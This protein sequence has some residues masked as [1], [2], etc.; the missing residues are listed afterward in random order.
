MTQLKDALFSGV[1]YDAQEGLSYTHVDCTTKNTDPWTR[2][3]SPRLFKLK[4]KFMTLKAEYDRMTELGSRD[5]RPSIHFIRSCRSRVVILPDSTM[6]TALLCVVLAALVAV[7]LSQTQCSDS[8]PCPAGLCCSKWGWCGIG[9]AWCGTN[10][11]TT[12]TPTTAA[13]ITA[14]FTTA[15]PTTATPTTAAPITATF[16]T[17]TPTFTRP[18]VNNT[19]KQ[20]AAYW[21]Q[22]TV[23]FSGNPSF[24]LQ[25]NIDEYCNDD[26]Y[27]ILIVS[28]LIQFFGPENVNGIPL[29]GLNLANT[30]DKT[31]DKYPTLL[32]CPHV[33]TAIKKC[34]A[35]G[36]K[37]ILSLGGASGAYGFF[38][39]D[40]PVQFAQTLW[41]MFLGGSSALPR[42]FG[43]AVFDGIDL[44]IEGGNTQYYDTFVKIMKEKYFNAADKKY[45][46]TGAPQC[47]FP[48]AYLSAAL[49]TGYF[50]YVFVQFYNNWCGLNNFGNPNAW[51]W[52]QWEDYASRHPGTQIFVGAPAATYAASTGYVSADQL[53]SV[54][55]SV[56]NSKA[57]GGIMIWDATVS[58][59]N[60]FGPAIA[61][62]NLAL[63]A[64]HPVSHT[65]E[66][67]IYRETRVVAGCWS[68][69]KQCWKKKEVWEAYFK[70]RGDRVE[71]CPGCHR[72]TAGSFIRNSKEAHTT[73]V[74]Q[75]TSAPTPSSNIPS[76][77][78]LRR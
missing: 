53:T 59:V 57:Y 28:F 67:D 70:V 2:S 49:E 55:N 63:S 58:S 77:N 31:S 73:F 40:Q 20:V 42:P 17:A 69:G 46:I 43:D 60:G 71:R 72:N 51:N 16:T 10:T 50:D 54:I 12:A 3:D 15:N 24:G 56:K 14:T 27:D 5:N 74:T 21:G 36:K 39:A 18:P 30:C 38:S 47:P 64:S 45:Y 4:D 65:I 11:P 6:R 1:L 78:H 35:N 7:S 23:F 33:G 62:A 32:D 52:N 41:D 76:T 61:R 44:D 34:Q 29:P 48:D 8:Q 9:A 26:T 75:P 19:R 37:V 66:W 25:K 13:P 22:D 68:R